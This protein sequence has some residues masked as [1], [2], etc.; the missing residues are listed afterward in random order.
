MKLSKNIVN[1][2]YYVTIASLISFTFGMGV[3]KTIIESEEDKEYVSLDEIDKLM[4]NTQNFDYG[5]ESC[6]DKSFHRYCKKIWNV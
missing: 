3:Q 2:I 6:V 1:L 5:L 4:L